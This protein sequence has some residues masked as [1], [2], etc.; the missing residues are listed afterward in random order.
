MYTKY[1]D[2]MG[3]AFGSKEPIIKEEENKFSIKVADV[4]VSNKMNCKP[5]KPSLS[6][7]D[8]TLNKD[9]EIAFLA[10]LVF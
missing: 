1:M 7:F 9:T 10:Y 5:Q 6:Y 3:S 8:I 2:G 4:T